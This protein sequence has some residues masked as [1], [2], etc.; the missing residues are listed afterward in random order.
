M[1]AQSDILAWRI[2]WTEEPG[3]LRSHRVTKSRTRLKQLST[4]LTLNNQ[5]GLWQ[6]AGCSLFL[7]LTVRGCTD[8]PPVCPGDETENG[9][10]TEASLPGVPV[11]SGFITC[12]AFIVVVFFFK[13]LTLRPLAN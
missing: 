6:Q 1:A 4:H 11:D 12:L 9:C 3:G 13:G 5:L 2:P 10:D 8:I 7:A